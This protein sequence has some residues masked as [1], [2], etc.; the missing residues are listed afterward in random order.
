MDGA[1]T[2]LTNRQREVLLH[3]AEGMSTREIA[4]YQS[5]SVKTIETHRASLMKRTARYS[6]AGLT[7][8]AVRE[9]LIKP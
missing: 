8:L 5:V 4:A 3:I 7:L 9:G 6:V 2:I 1:L